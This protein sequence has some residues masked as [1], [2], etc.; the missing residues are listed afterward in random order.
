MATFNVTTSNQYISGYVEYTET[1]GSDYITT[2]KSTLTATLYLRR[3][4]SYSGTP[5]SS[6]SCVLTF[7]IDG[8]TYTQ[9]LGTVTVP[10]GGSYVKIGSASKEITHNADGSYKTS[11]SVTYSMPY[12]NLT[13]SEQSSGTISLT[14]IPR[15][16][17]VACSSPYIGDNAIISI[18]YKSESFTHTITYQIGTLTGTVATKTS[19]KTPQ[20]I[21]SSIASQIYSQIPNDKEIKGTIYCTTYSGDTQVGEM[22]SANFKLYAKESECKPTI[23][24]TV[25]DT[26]EEVTTITGSNTKFVKYLSKPKVTIIATPKNS[27]SIKSYS[28][29]LNDGQTSNLQENTFDTIASNKITTKVVDTREYIATSDI[30]LDMIDYV[31]LHINKLE[32]T[33]PEGTSNEVILNLTGVFY[34]GS[35]TDEVSNSLEA[36]FKYKLYGA[37]EWTNGGDITLTTENNE[38]KVTNLS[39][40]EIFK[41][42]EEYQFEIT[43]KDKLMQVARK[44][45]IPKGQEVWWE[46]EDGVGVN[47]HFW[48][49]GV[50]LS[51]YYSIIQT[52][53]TLPVLSAG[54]GGYISLNVTIPTGYTDINAMFHTSQISATSGLQLTPIYGFVGGGDTKYI[55]YHA[56]NGTTKEETIVMRIICIKSSLIN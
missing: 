24:A 2:N 15:A 47:G 41:Y 46:G 36:N 14:T 9:N 20:L 33:R 7:K 26:N 4:N 44:E 10:N 39:L 45:P 49:N 5:T 16:S 51:N 30:D 11:I 54:A 18:D 6:T 38:F 23:S 37:N 32:L 55:H 34:N 50:D 22:Q 29:D 21:T 43:I 8:T 40:G 19:S 42:D 1:L 17:E 12:S 3:T 53:F 25:V 35:F 48:L 28:I 27:A 13:L 52:S 31:Q 56:P